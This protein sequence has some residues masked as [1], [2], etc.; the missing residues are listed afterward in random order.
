MEK[1]QLE[2]KVTELSQE[3]ATLNSTIGALELEI[4]RKDEIIILL[5]NP[6]S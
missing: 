3:I 4:R 6:K 5:K 2:A 1:E